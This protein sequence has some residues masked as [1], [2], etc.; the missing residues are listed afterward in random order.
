M[1]YLVMQKKYNQIAMFPDETSLVK[2]G[3][4]KKCQIQ[5][6]ILKMAIWVTSNGL[7]VNASK[8]EVR[9]FGLGGQQSITPMNQKIPRQALCKSLG[10][11]GNSKKNQR[12]YRLLSQKIE[13][14]QWTGL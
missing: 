7:T 1:I 10:L 5:Q 13:S 3:K 11:L 8:C 2:A 12:S 4:R 6:D 14:V 9:I